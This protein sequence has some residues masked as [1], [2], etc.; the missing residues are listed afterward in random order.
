MTKKFTGT[1]WGTYIHEVKN[2]KILFNYWKKDPNPSEFGLNFVSAA[3]DSLRIRQPHV[4]KGWLEKNKSLRGKDTY[5]PV[6]WENA[7]S[8]A[9]N[10]LER[11][12]LKYGNESIYAGSYGWAS[13]G[14]FHHAKSQVNR[15]FNLFGG[16]SYSQQSY[17]YAA[18]QTLLPHII[19]K[20]LYELLDDHTSW[21]ALSKKTELVLMFGGMPLKNAQLSSGGVG[22]H[23]T[24][25]GMKQC[26]NNGIKFVNISPQKTDSPSFLKADQIFIRPNTDTAL[27]LSLAYLLIVNNTYDKSFIKKYTVGFGEFNKYVTGDKNNK[28]CTPEWA[29]SITSISVKKINHLYEKIVTKKT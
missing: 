17:S 29:S 11:V 26:K 2:K 9:A 6:S 28:P 16:F 20:S 24:E 14:R 7:I 12:K 5:I 19:G 1:H 3:K 10:E 21:Q 18:A 23:T 4:R 15:F 27:M 22:K 25:A 13:A 8:F